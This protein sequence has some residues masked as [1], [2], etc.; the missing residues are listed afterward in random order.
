MTLKEAYEALRE[1]QMWRRGEGRYRIQCDDSLHLEPLPYSPKEV[2][3]ALDVAIE[4][5]KKEVGE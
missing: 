4:T 5:L 2:G 3:I 1:F